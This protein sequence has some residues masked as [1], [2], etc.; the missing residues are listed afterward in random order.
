MHLGR[1][2]AEIDAEIERR[3]ARIAAGHLE[4]LPQSRDTHDDKNSLPEGYS[5]L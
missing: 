3:R 4:D 2:R 1:L 5:G